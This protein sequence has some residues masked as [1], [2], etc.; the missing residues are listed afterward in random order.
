MGD[1]AHYLALLTRGTPT[2]EDRIA[3]RMLAAMS[4]DEC[5]QVVEDGCVCVLPP[6]TT[7]ASAALATSPSS[8][9]PARAD[10][11]HMPP[12]GPVSTTDDLQGQLMVHIATGSLAQITVRNTDDNGWW[13]QGGGGLADS[14][15]QS[16]DWVPL[17]IVVAHYRAT[18]NASQTLESPDEIQVSTPPQDA[19]P[20]EG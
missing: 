7:R 16:G 1:E 18:H 4:A 13:V 2:N 3:A 8:T 15:I 10:T 17:G 12:G 14:V 20:A 6:P 19:S 11:Q 9:A 5:G